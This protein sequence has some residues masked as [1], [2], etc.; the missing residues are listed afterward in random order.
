MKLETSVFELYCGKYM[1]LS[2]VARAMGISVP[3][4]YRVRQGRSPSTENPLQGQQEPFPDV[5]ST[6]FFYIVP[7]RRRFL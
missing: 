6:T 5:S 2:E 4:I 1:N 7:D 3:Q